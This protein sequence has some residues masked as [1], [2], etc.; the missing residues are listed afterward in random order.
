MRK[1]RS[2]GVPPV[3]GV[4][5]FCSHRE[6]S[7]DNSPRP[8]AGE[9]DRAAV[10]EGSAE[11]AGGEQPLTPGSAVP[12]PLGE[13]CYQ[14]LADREPECTNSRHGRPAR[15][16]GQ[17]GRATKDAVGLLSGLEAPLHTKRGHTAYGNNK[18]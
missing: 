8:L 9:G 4:C 14:R 10:D 18:I 2:T 13:G 5:T 16:H 12:S 15:A 17:D 3:P 11:L 7:A 6:I 1:R